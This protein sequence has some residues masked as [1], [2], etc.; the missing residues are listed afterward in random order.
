MYDI[1]DPP[2]ICLSLPKICNV[3]IFF[4]GIDRL[5][6]KLLEEGINVSVQYFSSNS[7]RFSQPASPPASLLA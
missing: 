6:E 4:S 2:E 3:Q 1:G 7:A 5:I